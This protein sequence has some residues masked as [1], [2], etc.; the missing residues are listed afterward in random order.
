MERKTG[1]CVCELD[2]IPVDRAGSCQP[3]MTL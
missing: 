2:S 3:V 1:V